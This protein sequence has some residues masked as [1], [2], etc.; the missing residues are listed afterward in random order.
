M[1]QITPD[2]RSRWTCDSSSTLSLLKNP[3]QI[4]SSERESGPEGAFSTSLLG[5]HSSHSL[6]QVKDKK[7]GGR[8]PGAQM[9][10]AEAPDKMGHHRD[11]SK[12]G[13]KRVENGC[14]A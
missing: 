7:N 8:K 5:E 13:V 10:T 9:G 11:K 2:N 4:L 1:W 6:G 3:S 14:R 12:P